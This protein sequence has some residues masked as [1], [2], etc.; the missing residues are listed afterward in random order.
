[1]WLMLEKNVSASWCR[2]RGLTFEKRRRHLK[3]AVTP[4]HE[5]LQ[6]QIIT[7]RFPICHNILHSPTEAKVRSSSLIIQTIFHTPWS[8][9]VFVW[10]FPLCERF[11]RPSYERQKRIQT[12]PPFAPTPAAHMFAKYAHY[13]PTPCNK[14][15]A[16]YHYNCSQS[17]CPGSPAIPQVR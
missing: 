4:L 6:S 16:R 13:M 1:M 7:D 5:P 17:A 14:I 11:D 8:V 15:A 3:H 10:P 12:A 2:T 9:R